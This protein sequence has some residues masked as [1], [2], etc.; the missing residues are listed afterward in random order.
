LLQEKIEVIGA[1]VLRENLVKLDGLPLI[2]RVC[3]LPDL[4]PETDIQVEISNV[5]LLELGFTARFLHKLH[6]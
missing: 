2:T 6:A 4:A 1:Q 3:S 5:D